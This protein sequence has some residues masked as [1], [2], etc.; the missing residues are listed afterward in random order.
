MIQFVFLCVVF[1][2]LAM[3]TLALLAAAL[4][5]LVMACIV[6]IPVWFT[7][8]HWMKQ[9]GIGAPIQQRIDRL[10]S[11]YL[12]GKIDL[13]EFERRVAQLISIER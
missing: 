12:D 2:I 4:V 6:G 9:R 3:I 10:R 8:R 7:V 5:F 1:L 13:F 11:L